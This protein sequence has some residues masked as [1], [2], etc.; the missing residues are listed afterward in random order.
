LVKEWCKGKH[1]SA[2]R[3]GKD[4]RMW[5]DKRV[6][7]FSDPTDHH[8]TQNAHAYTVD[9]AVYGKCYCAKGKGLSGTF[10]GRFAESTIKENKDVVVKPRFLVK[11]SNEEEVAKEEE[12]SK[13]KTTT[14]EED[15]EWV[16]PLKFEQKAKCIR[17]FLGKG[18]T[19][20]YKNYIKEM[21]QN[22]KVIVL[23]PRKSFA[24][25]ISN[26]LAF[27]DYQKVKGEIKDSRIVIQF[28]SLHRLK[29]SKF[30]LVVMDEVES[31]LKQM[32]S[33]K[34]NGNNLQEN[35]EKFE[36]ILKT[37]GNILCADAFLTSKTT[38]LLTALK[39]NHNIDIYKSKPV[40]RVI[41]KTESAHE[42]LASVI[43]SLKSGKKSYFFVSS[44]DKLL[45][46]ELEIT[47]QVPGVRILS[48]HGGKKNDY[49]NV[50]E[51]WKEYDL[52]MTTASMTVGIDFNDEYFDELFTYVSASSQNIIRDIAQSQYRVRKLQDNRLTFYIDKRHFGLNRPCD[53]IAVGKEIDKNTRVKNELHHKYFDSV[54]TEPN[55]LRNLYI[56]NLLE[57]NRSIM[58]C[59][60]EWF[61][62]MTECNYHEEVTDLVWE[63]QFHCEKFDDFDYFELDSIGLD[64]VVELQHLVRE[65]TATEKDRATIEKYYF[66]SLFDARKL[67]KSD[68]KTLAGLW[69][70]WRDFGKTKIRN[71]SFEKGIVNGTYS[72]GEMV[73][74]DSTKN[75]FPCLGDNFLWRYVTIKK[76]MD[77]LE[78][79]FSNR[80]GCQI[81]RQKMEAALPTIQKNEKEMREAFSLRYRSR[82]EF[83]LKSCIELINSILEKW[84]YSKLRKGKKT[85]TRVNGKQVDTTPFELV[86]T[87]SVDDDILQ[88]GEHVVGRGGK[89]E[90]ED[91][92]EKKRY[93]P[94]SSR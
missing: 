58:Q 70:I 5:R 16:L 60:Q 80:I 36:E 77:I 56:D 24:S 65:G 88:I 23:T 12:V 1:L 32:T 69:K 30:D 37:A 45:N 8:S 26:E 94:L 62:F 21:S 11:E 4:I 34:T 48:C 71:L 59:E 75:P 92:A 51:K 82:G 83:N 53:R 84:G 93:L 10:I 66:C 19:T 86:S 89:V 35:I 25:N 74:Y 33:V 29:D 52:I 31:I 44:K 61:K 50:N 46:F 18:K 2:T 27:T 17:A 63:V 13:T 90:R 79:D 38:D 49:Q 73:A 55:Y 20:C 85:R 64:K 3:D 72:I 91:V 54:K 81:S 6:R 22:S 40:E 47:K 68:L 57:E 43:T 15:V 7:C 87:A 28:E 9:G 78:L 39:I 67:M 14:Y 41:V 42:L 76:L